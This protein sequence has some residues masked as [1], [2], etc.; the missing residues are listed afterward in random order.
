MS[1]DRINS[2]I[3]SCMMNKYDS[4][5]ID[6]LKGVDRLKVQI[7]NDRVKGYYWLDIT[8]TY[9][10]FKLIH[11]YHFTQR[12]SRVC[13]KFNPHHRGP[14]SKPHPHMRLKPKLEFCKHYHILFH[15]ISQI[16]L[17]FEID[18]TKQMMNQ[19][20]FESAMCQLCNC[21]LPEPHAGGSSPIASI[22]YQD[23]SPTILHYCIWKQ[24][25]QTAKV[26]DI[27]VEEEDLLGLEQENEIKGDKMKIHNWSVELNTTSVS[28]KGDDKTSEEDLLDFDKINYIE[29][30]SEISVTEEEDDSKLVEGLKED[31]KKLCK[32]FDTYKCG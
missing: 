25:N 24:I 2:I 23:I 27:E 9:S 30:T 32:L 8:G 20:L 26:D 21:A 14:T 11:K 31:V 7:T 13:W 3:D 22:Y 17:I 19:T 4:V 16:E 18:I 15:I 29:Q 28:I 1:K 6:K 10:I 12:G 5:I